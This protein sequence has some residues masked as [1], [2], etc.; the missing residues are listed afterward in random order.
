MRF[1]TREGAEHVV[2]LTV[3]GGCVGRHCTVE[4]IGTRFGRFEGD[5]RCGAAGFDW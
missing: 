2:V 5:C 1:L 3:L 4:T